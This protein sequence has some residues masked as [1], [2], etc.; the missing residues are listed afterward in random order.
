TLLYAPPHF[1]KHLFSEIIARAQRSRSKSFDTWFG[2][3][4]QMRETFLSGKKITSGENFKWKIGNMLMFAPLKNVYGLSNLR[5]AFT[6]GDV[7]GG[8]VF[9]FFRGIGVHLKKTY[10]TAESAGFICVQGNAQLNSV[11]GENSMGAPLEGVEIKQIAG[12]EIAFKGINAFKKYYRD[13]DATSAIIDSD[14]WVKTGDLGEIDTQGALDVTDRVDS[15]GKFSSGTMFV[16][17]RIEAA[18]KSS[19]YILE[20]VAIGDG[21]DSISAFVV[22]DGVTVGSWAEVNNIRFAGYRDLAT[23]QEVYDLVKKSIDEVNSHIAETEGESCP[24]VKRFAVM[25]REFNVDQGEITRS[26][27]V[28]RDVVM[29]THQAL[30]NAMYSSQN[31]VQVK[32]D[33]SGQTVAELKIESV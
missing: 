21:Q 26:H 19:P 4:K 3:S 2:F 5:K 6:G 16:P 11:T 1:Y 30:V 23:K 29:G 12:G 15:V 9:N 31:S 25:H 32:D 24:P 13:P 22:I 27:K 28:K 14:G 18:L 20:A 33:S 8:E 7:M 17:H 10:G